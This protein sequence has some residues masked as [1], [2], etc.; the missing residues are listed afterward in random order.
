MEEI[1]LIA[2]WTL[3]IGTLAAL[4]ALP[5]WMLLDLVISERKSH[6][7]HGK[8]ILTAEKDRL[9][10][11]V[12]RCIRCRESWLR[13]ESVDKH[14]VGLPVYY[15]PIDEDKPEYYHS[16]KALKV[17]NSKPTGKPV[18]YEKHCY[19]SSKAYVPLYDS[20]KK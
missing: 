2:V 17:L 13:L 6:P 1:A 16:K 4:G 11:I 19:V 14:C 18:A 7:R 20:T 12:H 5:V 9:G 10:F 3:F 15:W 8:H